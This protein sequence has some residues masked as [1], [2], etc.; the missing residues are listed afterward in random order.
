MVSLLEKMKEIMELQKN[1]TLDEDVALMQIRK[2]LGVKVEKTDTFNPVSESRRAPIFEYG[3]GAKLCYSALKAGNHS[4]G[5][6][7]E[8]IADLKGF[9]KRV[10]Y[11]TIYSQLGFLVSKNR[12]IKRIIDEEARF[13]THEQNGDVVE[14]QPGKHVSTNHPDFKLNKDDIEV[15]EEDDKK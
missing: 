14:F 2:M 8:Y 10:I 5:E 12:I 15:D 1:G 3:E 9:E 11:G 7:I 4:T 6:I 13:Y